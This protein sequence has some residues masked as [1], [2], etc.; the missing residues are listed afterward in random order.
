MRIHFDIHSR[1]HITLIVCLFVVLKATEG[2]EAHK[3]A[4][5]VYSRIQLFQGFSFE[6][7]EYSAVTT[8]Q[9]ICKLF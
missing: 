4:I 9:L 8:Q 7:A 1:Q 5:T 2:K 3:L 6:V